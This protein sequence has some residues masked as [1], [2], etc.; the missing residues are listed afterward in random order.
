MDQRPWVIPGELHY[1]HVVDQDVIIGYDFFFNWINEGKTPATNCEMRRDYYFATAEEDTDVTHFK[2]FRNP[3]AAKPIL[4]P[5]LPHPVAAMNVP[6]S[7]LMDAHE[8]KGS[9]F[10]SSCME[11]YFIWTI[12]YASD[13]PKDMPRYSQVCFKV[14]FNRRPDLLPKSKGDLPFEFM[15]WGSQNGIT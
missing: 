9:I 3:R 14:G 6:I 7:T 5:G 8:G 13:T 12:P 15:P 11:Y 2:F 4:G 1:Q 10:V